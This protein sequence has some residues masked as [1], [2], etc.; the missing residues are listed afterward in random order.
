MKGCSRSDAKSTNAAHIIRL[1]LEPR[2]HS[3]RI[4]TP[5]VGQAVGYAWRCLG[6]CWGVSKA[7]PYVL[8]WMWDWLV[9]NAEKVGVLWF[10]SSPITEVNLSLSCPK[11][12]A[13]NQIL[14]LQSKAN[15]TWS[16]S[17]MCNIQLLVC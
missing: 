9:W 7:E 11:N 14:I 8:S 17:S 6:R 12:Y 4:G 13:G 15:L 2:Y 5:G 10:C 16:L 1:Q 3:T